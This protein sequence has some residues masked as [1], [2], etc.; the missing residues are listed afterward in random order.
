MQGPGQ[1]SYL[2]R[3]IHIVILFITF[4]K[5]NG[6]PPSS[7]KSVAPSFKEHW[8]LL[9]PTF[10]LSFDELLQSKVLLCVCWHKQINSKPRANEH[11]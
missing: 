1:P 10:A 3:Q 7:L 2:G 4:A 9:P 5:Q 8:A 6:V 11:G